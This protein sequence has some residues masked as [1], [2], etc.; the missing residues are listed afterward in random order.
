M[1][2]DESA[3]QAESSAWTGTRGQRKRQHQRR[4]AAPAPAPAPKRQ[5]SAPASAC[6]REVLAS[7]DQRVSVQQVLYQQRVLAEEAGR[8]LR[9]RTVIRHHNLRRARGRGQR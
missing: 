1:G 3:M 5:S 7:L 6:L 4:V 9:H 2:G 8:L